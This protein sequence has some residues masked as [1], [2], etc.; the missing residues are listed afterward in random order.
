VGNGAIVVQEA[1]VAVQ[2]GATPGRDDLQAGPHRFGPR[3]KANAVVADL[4][5][6]LIP[7]LPGPGLDP[8]LWAP[9]EGV[10]DRVEDKLVRDAG[11]GEERLG[12]Q[13]QRGLV[14]SKTSYAPRNSSSLRWRS[15]TS[16]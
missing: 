3:G 4:H 6:V 10:L 14:N 2:V 9:V 12:G 5:N 1:A 11:E 15:V 16:L 8:P 13:F 7:L